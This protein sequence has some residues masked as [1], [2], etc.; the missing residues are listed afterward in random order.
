MV[1]D[2]ETLEYIYRKTDGYCHICKKKL[3][4]KNYAQQ[5]YKG[6]WEVEHSK[7]KGSG[8]TDYLRNLYPACITCNREKGMTSTK[9]AR[10]WHGRRNKPLSKEKKKRNRTRNTIIG[11]AVGVVGFAINPFIGLIGVITGGFIG[12]NIDPDSK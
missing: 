6:A 12:N 1:Y 10:A 9:T 4:F 2:K 11:M 7:P 3:S 8:G 5:G